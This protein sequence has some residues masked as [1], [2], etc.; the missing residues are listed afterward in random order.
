MSVKSAVSPGSSSSTVSNVPG[1]VTRWPTYSAG[2]MVTDSASAVAV[3]IG[4]W[5]EKACRLMRV[6]VSS[7]TL[8]TVPVISTSPLR[9]RSGLIV[10]MCTRSGSVSSAGAAYAGASAPLVA[11]PRVR[12]P[13]RA[14]RKDDGR[15]T[16]R[17]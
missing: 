4:A 14:A 5:E 8:V 17:C 3:G 16:H 9:G 15:G 10:S 11:A 7:L 13:A 6:K 1:T 2:S 12:S